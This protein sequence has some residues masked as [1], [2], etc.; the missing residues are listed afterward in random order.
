[1]EYAAVGISVALSL[2]LM[3]SCMDLIDGA[4]HRIRLAAA[5]P[6]YWQIPRRD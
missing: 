3:M 4:Q 5:P 2:C 6:L 1:M